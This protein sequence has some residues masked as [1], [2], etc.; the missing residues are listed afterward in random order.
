MR[1]FPM[2]WRR[3]WSAQDAQ[4]ANEFKAE[5]KEKNDAQFNALRL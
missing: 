5:R 3:R 1:S 2:P 4:D